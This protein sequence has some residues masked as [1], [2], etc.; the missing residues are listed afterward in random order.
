MKKQDREYNILEKLSN[1]YIFFLLLIF[2]F[3]VDKTG[4]FRIFEV[5]W[6]SYVF[7]TSIYVILNIFIILYYLVF[8]KTNIFT[9]CKPKII[10]WLALLF[11]LVNVISSFFSPY[12]SNHNLFIG[13][14]RGEGLLTM[15]LYSLSFIFISLFIKFK[16][17]YINYFVIS[18]IF[19]SL[20][21]ILQYIGFNPFNMYQDGIGTHNVSFMG[22][23]GNIDFL[24]ALYTIYLSISFGAYVF[25]EDNTKFEKFIYT[26]SFLLGFFIFGV[27]NVRSGKVALFTTLVIIFPFLLKNNKRLSK[28]LLLIALFLFAYAFNVFINPAFHYELGK[29]VLH[30]RFNIY[31]LLFI[32]VISVLVLLSKYINNIKFD[33]SDKKKIV[34]YYYLSLLF[35]IMISALS[36]Y[37][38]DFKSGFLYEIHELLHGNFKDEFGTYRVFL[39]KRTIKLIP[40]APL[41]GTGSD[42]FVLRFMNKYTSDVAAIGTLTLN[43]TAANVYLTMIINIG[44]LGLI[45]YLSFLFFQIKE[46][47]KK[48][49]NY[50]KVLLIAIIC[51][52]VEDFFNI[53]LVITTPIFWLVMALH[54]SSIFNKK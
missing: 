48:M 14:G 34:K 4:F 51:Y 28:F 52:I 12:F 10:Q 24:C 46:G 36:I 22:T 5:K 37:F 54:F 42:T 6:Y 39:W 31:I 9:K 19:I 11:M 2:P 16:K 30:Y 8:K 25:L 32:I 40:E 15:S 1:I 20:I 43:D 3:L 45:N 13:V 38:I 7:V 21:C 18:S 47:I 27:I 35:L 26:L 49:N 53:S 33:F 41:I 50:S 29:I 23:I 44:I 17:K